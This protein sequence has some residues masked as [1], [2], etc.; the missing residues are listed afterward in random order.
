MT[1]IIR[2][3]YEGGI[4]VSREIEGSGVSYVEVAKLCVHL[5]IAIS[6]ALIAALSVLDRLNNS[7]ANDPSGVSDSACRSSP[8]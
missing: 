1:R 8:I 5:V 4:L 3:K 7:D 2:E 6:I